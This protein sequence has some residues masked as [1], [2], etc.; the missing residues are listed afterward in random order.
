MTKMNPLFKQRWVDAL[1]SGEYEQGQHAMNCQGKF[2][3]LGV[4][5]E[6]AKED[7]NTMVTTGEL[8]VPGELD[9]V[10]VTAT[11]YNGHGKLPS[12]SH[13][14]AFF[15]LA[16][17]PKVIING[18]L[19]TLYGHNDRGRTFLEIADAIEAQL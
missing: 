10:R 19:R 11:L 5:E 18:D 2:C 17:V 6:I 1:R 12:D 15:N 13:C 14:E 9:A 7:L 4:L 3:C 16:G 8:S